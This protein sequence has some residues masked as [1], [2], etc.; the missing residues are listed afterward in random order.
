M[1]LILF[2]FRTEPAS[3]GAEAEPFSFSFFL[4]VTM[5]KVD[6]PKPNLRIQTGRHQRSRTQAPTASLAFLSKGATHARA[7]ARTQKR[8]VKLSGRIHSKSDSD[9]FFQTFKFQN[10]GICEVIS[11]TS[12]H[13]IRELPLNTREAGFT[14]TCVGKS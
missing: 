10:F 2:F 6:S 5:Q 12:H 4:P 1:T 14:S 7:C 13:M 11:S 9:P 8:R 3:G